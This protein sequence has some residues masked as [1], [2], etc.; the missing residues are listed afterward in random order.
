MAL[1]KLLSLR[2]PQPPDE[3]PGVRSIVDEALAVPQLV[4]A[5]LFAEN[6]VAL[7]PWWPVLLPL[8]AWVGWRTYRSE[9][10]AVLARQAGR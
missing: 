6:V 9:R 10:A 3:A 2:L 8:L 7:R 5:R 1:R 4:S